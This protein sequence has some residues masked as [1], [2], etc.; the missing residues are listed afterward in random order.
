MR[1]DSA[2]ILVQSSLLEALGGGVVTVNN[3]LPL[4]QSLT[5]SLLHILI[6]HLSSSSSIP[7]PQGSLGHN[8]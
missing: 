6:F 1:D 5:L 2:E 8:R 4:Q 7:Y 3:L